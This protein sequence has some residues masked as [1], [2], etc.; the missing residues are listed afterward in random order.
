MSLT[1]GMKVALGAAG[2]GLVGGFVAERVVSGSSIAKSREAE[3][4]NRMHDDFLRQHPVPDGVS[5]RVHS[6][7]AWQNAA[8]AGGAAA[9]VAALGGGI[10][11]AA[12][13][14]KAPSYPLFV[15]GLATAALGGAA[16]LGVGASWALR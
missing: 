12:T 13:R 11:F 16:A 14:L 7:P 4:W 10:A 15:A 5:V 8:I 9:G 2:A 6:T 3:I 1:T